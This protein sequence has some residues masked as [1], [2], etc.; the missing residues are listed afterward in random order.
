M[1]KALKIFLMFVVFFIIGTVLGTLLYSL[2]LGTLNH[3][4]GTETDFFTETNIVPAFFLATQVLS[5]ITGF[6]LISYRIRHRGGILQLIAFIITQVVCWTVIMPS[7]FYLENYYISKHTAEIEAEKSEHKLTKGYFRSSN[8]TTYY[9][10]DNLKHSYLPKEKGT[11]AVRI[12]TKETGRVSVVD[13]RTPNLLGII[14]LAE[15]YNDILV[16]ESFYEKSPQ[17]L[18]F[19]LE[20]VGRAK[21]N[22]MRGWT[23]WLGFVS[24]GFA[25]TC[26]YGL[27]HISNWRLISFSVCSVVAFA[28]LYWNYG[29]Y[30]S[31]FDDFRQTKIANINIGSLGNYVENQFLLITNLLI[32]I[33]MIVIG[34]I[35][36]FVRKHHAN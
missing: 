36:H 34:I 15:P 9:F 32:G 29:Y 24:L 5:I 10:M 6:L 12:N 22:F 20:L 4:V 1:K 3:V 28:L 27:S 7:S 2:Y 21:K 33:V 13:I 30:T 26:I 18:S 19:L 17:G 11:T 14:R 16:K 35:L 25:L 8:N 23:F 31:I